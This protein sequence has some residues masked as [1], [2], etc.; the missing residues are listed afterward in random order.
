LTGTGLGFVQADDNPDNPCPD[1]WCFNCEQ[2]KQAN[3]GEWPENSQT[4]TPIALVC[5]DC[6]EEIRMNNARV[7]PSTNRLMQ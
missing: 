1:A 5:G 3:G 4:Q 6:Y 7:P 2:V